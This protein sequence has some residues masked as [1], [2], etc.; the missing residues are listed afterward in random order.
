MTIEGKLLQNLGKRAIMAR[1][2]NFF[3][4][5]SINIGNLRVILGVSQITLAAEWVFWATFLIEVV[6]NNTIHSV[7]N[8]MRSSLPARCFVDLIRQ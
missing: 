5:D 6:N 7:G 1:F 2:I 3:Y 4:A 8:T